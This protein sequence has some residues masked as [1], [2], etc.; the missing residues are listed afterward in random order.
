[1]L[2]HH[3]VKRSLRDKC[4]MHAEEFMGLQSLKGQSNGKVVLKS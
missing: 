2:A 1:M 4:K 3:G